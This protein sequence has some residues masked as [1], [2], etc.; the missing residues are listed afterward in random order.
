[1]ATFEI[2]FSRLRLPRD[3]VAMKLTV[4]RTERQH[5]EIPDANECSEQSC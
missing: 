4:V 3:A 1:M 2:H 5:D